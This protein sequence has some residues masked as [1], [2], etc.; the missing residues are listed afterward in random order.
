MSMP[1]SVPGAPAQ[2]LLFPDLTVKMVTVN[3]DGGHVS[4]DGGGVLLAQLDRS[5]GYLQRFSA[6]FRDYRDPELLEHSLLELLRQRVYALGLGYEDLNDHDSLRSDPLLASLC[7]KEDPLGQDRQ[8]EQ[9]RGKA[10]SGKSTLN[11]LELTPA[12]ASASSRYKKIVADPT[13]LE[14]YFI[15]EYVRSVAKGT[16]EVI[17]DLDRTNDPVYGDQEGRF[18]HG[19]YEEYCYTPLYIFGGHWPIV[20]ALHTGE[21]EHQQEILRLVAKIVSRLRCKLPQVRIILRGDSG[22]CRQELMLWCERNDVRYV[23]GLA[24]NKVLERILRGT[25]RTAKS[26]LDFNHSQSERLFKD[27]RY[28]AKTW[29]QKRRV[30][31]KA[32]WTT[33]GANPRFVITNLTIEEFAPAQELYEQ[34]YCG[35]GNMENR[36]KEQKLDLFAGR[37]STAT[38]RANQLRL[39]FSTLAYLLMNKLRKVT[40]VGTKLAEATC[41]TIRLQLFKIGAVVRVTARRV[42]VCLS[43]AYPLQELFGLAARRLRLSASG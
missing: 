29:E 30:A 42:W 38:L 36:I 4:S 35:R 19:Y 12:E 7:G 28:R 39:L 31:G 32:E 41:G 9:D 21:S 1:N 18:F 16:A 13:A 37:T 6:C 40:L 20:A 11:R 24:K 3:F 17:L 2:S 33:E 14:D 5:Y 27:F 26:M 43:S 23:F 22:F 8:R 15:D 25:L 34:L 10:L